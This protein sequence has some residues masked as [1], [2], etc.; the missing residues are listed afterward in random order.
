MWRFRLGLR[1]GF[2]LRTAKQRGDT[3][4]DRFDRAFLD[5]PQPN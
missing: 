3:L 1:C 2:C 4:G 5:A